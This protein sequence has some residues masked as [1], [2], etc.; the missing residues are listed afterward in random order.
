MS[1]TFGR[2]HVATDD[3]AARANTRR[4]LRTREQRQNKSAKAA[5]AHDRRELREARK[6]Y[7]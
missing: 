1:K 7:R 2:A 6:D 3:Y 4:R 5:R